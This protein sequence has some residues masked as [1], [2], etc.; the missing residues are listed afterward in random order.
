MSHGSSLKGILE[1]EEE[2]TVIP[3]PEEAEAM[4]AGQELLEAKIHNKV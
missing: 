1:E 3:H 2:E 4:P